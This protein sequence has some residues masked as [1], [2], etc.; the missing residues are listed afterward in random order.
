MKDPA[1]L[2]IDDEAQLRNML[3]RLFA[4]EGYA[5]TTAEDGARAIARL[6]TQ[7]VAVVLCGVKLPDANG[8]ELTKAIKAVRPAAEVILF[9]AYGN[10][11]DAVLAMQNGAFAYLVKGDDND[12]LLP[13]VASALER[14]RQRQQM[15]DIPLTTKYIATKAGVDDFIAEATPEDKMAYIKKEQQDG[16]LV[17]MMGDGTNDAPALA[18]ADVGV[19]MNSSMQGAKEAGNMEIST[20]TPPN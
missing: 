19:A 12:R 11:P 5:V 1:L 18:L 6:K 3:Q 17:A 13:T 7:D 15:A 2:I 8:V 4:G 14:Y 20:T 10:I 16:K 9:T